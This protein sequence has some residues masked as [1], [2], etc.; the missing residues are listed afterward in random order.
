MALL[1]PVSDSPYSE[2]LVSL[3]NRVITMVFKFNVVNQSW[4]LDL[5]DSRGLKIKMGI[6][7][8]ANQNLTER[9]DLSD[10][11]TGD[12][13]CIKNRNSSKVLGRT[14]LGKNKDYGLY[15]IS[16]EDSKLLGIENVIQF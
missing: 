7:I 10:S 15:W 16:D 12:L 11:F 13:W 6:R 5:L 4:Y 1:I 3:S 8:V 9:F 14:N 2:Q